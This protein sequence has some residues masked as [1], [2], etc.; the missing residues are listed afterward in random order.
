MKGKA[1]VFTKPGMPMEI[2]EYPLPQ[3]GLGAILV[4]VN[5]A[6]I[7]GS[8]V[9][10]WKGEFSWGVADKPRIIGHEMVGQ[11]YELGAGVNTD[12]IGQPLKVGDRVTYCYFYPCGHCYACLHGQ[13]HACPNILSRFAITCEE[14]PH[15]IGAYA[16]YFYIHPGQFICKVPDEVTDEM[17]A[18]ANCAL[19]QVFYGLHRVGIT[20]GDTVVIQGAGG[21]GINAIAVAREMGAGTIIVVEQ[22]PERIKL[23][24]AFG[25]DY[26]IDI[27]QYPTPRERVSRVRQLTKGRGGADVVAE[28]T[29]IPQVVREGVGMVRPGGRYLWIGNIKGGQT[30]EIDPSAI[31]VGNR[32]IV[33]VCTYEPWALYRAMDLLRRTRDKYPFSQILSHSFKL[34]EINTAFE[35]A[36]QGKVT[37]ATIV[38]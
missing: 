33:G 27:G 29:G 15:F 36:V 21:L 5:R 8:D 17:A 22:H 9:H 38:M 30:V 24:Q 19:S 16:E 1:A 10:I 32:T 11:V 34:E 12:S 7:C 35:Q 2:R 26:T 18:P 37:R 20:I 13:P 3:V 4:R 31:V 14:P 25:A 23:A 28:L 6:N